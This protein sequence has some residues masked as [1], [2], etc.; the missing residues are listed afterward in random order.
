M[1]YLDIHVRGNDQETT[2]QGIE[3]GKKYHPRPAIRFTFLLCQYIIM[4][5]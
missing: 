1:G 4:P 2:Y 3:P 5:L